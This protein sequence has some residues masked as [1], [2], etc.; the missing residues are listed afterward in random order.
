MSGVSGDADF[1]KARAA[2]SC[3]EGR[4]TQGPITPRVK[5]P[6]AARRKNCVA[7]TTDMLLVHCGRLNEAWMSTGQ[8]AWRGKPWGKSLEPKWQ[9]LE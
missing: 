2:P 9:W 8:S 6:A 5:L 3:C 4:A 7:A 1:A